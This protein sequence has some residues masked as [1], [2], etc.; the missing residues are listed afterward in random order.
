MR[1][2][3]TLLLGAYAAAPV[4]ADVEKVKKVIATELRDERRVP[5]TIVTDSTGRVVLTCWYAPSISELRE[6]LWNSDMH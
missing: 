2:F 5:A 3:L 4:W 6:L 1:T